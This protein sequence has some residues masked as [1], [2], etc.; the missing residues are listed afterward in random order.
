[1]SI[2]IVYYMALDTST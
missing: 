2:F 1:M